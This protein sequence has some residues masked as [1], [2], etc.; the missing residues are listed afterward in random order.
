M[1][2]EPAHSEQ[3]AKRCAPARLVRRFTEELPG[4]KQTSVTPRQVLGAAFSRVKPAL[5]QN[6]SLVGWN[7]SLASEYGLSALGEDKETAASVFS[8]QR[9]LEG[10]D[11]YA[12]AYGGHQ[13][14]NWAGQLG[15][16]R[17]IALGDVEPPGNTTT[18]TLQLKGAGP[19]PYSRRADGLAVLRSSIRE[20]LASEAMYHLGVPTTRALSLVLTGDEVMRDILYDGNPA[21]EPGAIVCRTAPSF[22]RFGNFELFASR[23]EFDELRQLAD[24]TIRHYFAHLDNSQS[25]TVDTYQAWFEEVCDSTAE[26]MVEWMRVGFVHGVLN[27]D[28]MSIHGISI[29]YGPYG[30]IDDFDPSW[31]PNTTD[32]THRRYR[33]GNQGAV[34]QWNILQLA[35]A[36][37]PL[38]QDVASLEKSVNGYGETF[39]RKHQT[40]MMN[41]IGLE[42]TSES[43][44]SDAELVDELLAILPLTETDMTIFYRR[45]ADV[46][47]STADPIGTIS[48]AY[49][50]VSAVGG[51]IR[52][53]TTAWFAKYQQRLGSAG[54]G[55]AAERVGRM[56]QANPCY[57]L[58]NYLAQEAIDSATEGDFTKMDKLA[59]TLENPYDENPKAT[60]FSKK[61]PDWARDRVGCSM[62]S[63][64]S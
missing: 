29:D 16:G 9:L 17:A 24:F 50:D 28:N 41:K 47:R 48:N 36:I 15:D 25:P 2:K 35:N 1:P 49:Y 11:P 46:D 58:R 38:V 52:D 43:V 40:M 30:W 62:L 32:S 39:Q 21:L 3:L 27:T 37:V 57:I 19:T 14:G 51:D 4:D 34:G 44:K 55:M 22:I 53:R 12:M 60:E 61:R 59:E 33:F 5:V 42:P 7:T 26:L 64:S 20:Y 54:S 31:T 63:C 23:G 10:S 6:P 56:N 13:F 18:Q 45:L 8:G